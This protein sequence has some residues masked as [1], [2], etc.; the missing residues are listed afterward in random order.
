MVR[1]W[2]GWDQLNTK[3]LE[4][5][6][7]AQDINLQTKDVHLQE[8]NKE[9]LRDVVLVNQATMRLDGGPI[10]G[11]GVIKTAT[12]TDNTKTD[13]IRPVGGELYVLNS[14]SADVTNGSGTLTYTFFM[15][16]GTNSIRWFYYQ[17]SGASPVFQADGDFPD[18]PMYFDENIAMQFTV[19]GTYDSVQMN[20]CFMRIR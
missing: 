9:I 17:S 7:S 15:T 18:M 19:S 4:D 2:L 6:S 16:D 3:T 10:A 5:G 20:G 12:V 11:S 8:S 1:R 13:L 14:I